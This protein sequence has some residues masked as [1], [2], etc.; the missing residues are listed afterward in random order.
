MSA[1][2]LE[3]LRRLYVSGVDVE[4]NEAGGIRLARHRPPPE[5]LEELRAPKDQVR[6]LLEAQRAGPHDD[7]LQSPLPCRYA[8][9]AGCLAPRLCP[10][11]GPCSR[12][13]TCRPC[14]RAERTPVETEA[15]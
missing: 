12:F 3:L 6:G 14:D 13:L 5:L 1:S 2:A 10:R 11:L 15:A 8:I 9:P 7:G 4:L